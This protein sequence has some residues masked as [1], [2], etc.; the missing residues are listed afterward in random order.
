MSPDDAFILDDSANH[1]EPAI[2][3]WVGSRA[4]RTERRLALEYGQR[5]LYK[6]RQSGGRAALATHIVRMDQGRETD[7]FIAAISS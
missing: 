4:S 3:V 6:H 5:Y 1:A 2:Y 7:A